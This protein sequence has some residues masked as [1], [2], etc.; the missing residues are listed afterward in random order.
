MK[1]LVLVGHRS[2]RFGLLKTLHQS[3]LVEVI[4][5]R[6]YDDTERLDNTA[7][8]ESISAKLARID[9]AF[10]FL[11]AQKKLA[12]KR[13][14]DTKGS[15][16]PY[17]YNPVKEQSAIV[18]MDYTDFEMISTKEFEL[19]TAI[20]DLEQ[21]SQKQSD[22]NSK[23]L[24]L[25]SENEVLKI[26]ESLL[27]PFAFYKNTEMTTV[28]VGC[29][30]AQK[31]EELKALEEKFEGACIE[32]FDQ[33]KYVPFVAV[34]LNEIEGDFSIALQELDFVKCAFNYTD[35]AVGRID[36]NNQMIEAL[37]EEN[38]RLMEQA[39]EKEKVQRD[40]K[41]L[42]DFYFVELE[43]FNALDGFAATDKAFILEGWYPAEQEE[44]LKALLD[45]TSESF[46]Y[47]FKAPEDGDKVPTL[48]RSNKIVKPYEDITNMYSVPNYRGDLDPNPL[49]AFFYFFLFGIMMADFVYGILLAVGGFALYYKKKP[50]PGKGG[51]MLIIAMGGISTA[52][53]GLLFNSFLGFSP[54]PKALLFSPLDEPLKML[55]LCY[56]IGIVH[57]LSGMVIDAINKFKHGQAL[58]AVFADFTWFAIFIGIGLIVL[59]MFLDTIPAFVK[60]IGIGLAALGVFLILFS[61]TIGKK[62]AGKIKG[63]FGKA[64]K[65]YDLVNYLSDILSYS[66]LFG[67]CLSG[68][69]VAMVVNKICEVIALDIIGANWAFVL[70]VPIYMFGHIFNIAI[71]A[72]G[73][74]VH[75]CRLQ[76]IEYFGKFY[77][78]G[79]HQFVPFASMTK[80]TYVEMPVEQAQQTK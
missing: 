80:Y 41:T 8:K 66:R 3:K 74:Y 64:G 60:Y 30:P 10:D 61:G 55:I 23:K 68:G 67:L 31:I 78:G 37:D 76:Y 47:E 51:L 25:Q 15:Q 52:I 9:F 49:M 44:R 70:C 43:K 45:E 5:T 40:F 35:T 12:E 32:T 13:Q 59:P 1:K 38:F 73:A 17:I 71:S 6:H 39:L 50:V 34:V 19:F 21:I 56:V 24:K 75:N 16:N 26:Y 53:W 65:L 42:H 79:G 46:V 20:S 11:K 27:S 33:G 36:R 77:E 63:F 22:N 4:S 72:L 48:V 18:R 28:I 54:M 57:I 58:E 69:V 62:G 14:K 29:V 7:T 2:D